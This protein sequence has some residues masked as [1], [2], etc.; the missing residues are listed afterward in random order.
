MSGFR[1]GIMPCMFEELKRQGV[2]SED[3]PSGL[4][5]IDKTASVA[6]TNF[7]WLAQHVQKMGLSTCATLDDY[8]KLRMMVAIA[9]F[10]R[11]GAKGVGIRFRGPDNFMN[12]VPGA[13]L[14]T[15]TNEQAVELLK[16]AM[17]C[18]IGY[19]EIGVRAK[20]VTDLLSQLQ[21]LCPRARRFR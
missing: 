15:F 1:D 13:T 8:R 21:K 6:I 19:G 14:T 16:G 5:L 17:A 12:I 9:A 18:D 3:L 2:S 11:T 10:Q 4:E 7:V 20:P